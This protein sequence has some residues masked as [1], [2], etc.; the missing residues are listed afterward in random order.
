MNCGSFTRWSI[1][2]SSENKASFP[3]A[4]TWEVLHFDRVAHLAGVDCGIKRG[5]AQIGYLRDGRMNEHAV[6]GETKPESAE[7]QS[8]LA[9]CSDFCHV[10][11]SG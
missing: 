10:K 7:K 4:C 1:F 9:S 2:Y 11:F 6:N 8:H 5:H 3:H